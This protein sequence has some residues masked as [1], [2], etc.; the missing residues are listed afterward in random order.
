M[1]KGFSML[2]ISLYV[3]ILATSFQELSIAASTLE[4]RGMCSKS[5]EFDRASIVFSVEHLDKKPSIS[6][7]KTRSMY[8]KLLISFKALKLKHAKFKTLSFNVFEKKKWVQSSVGSGSGSRQV[9]LGHVAQMGLKVET[10]EFTRI[11]ELITSANKLGIKDIS[12]FSAFLSPKKRN[13]V[14]LKCLPIAVRNAKNKAQVLSESSGTKL[15]KVLKLI[16]S[17]RALERSPRPHQDAM[18][19]EAGMMSKAAAAPLAI[20]GGEALVQ[21]FVYMQYEV[22]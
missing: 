5:T 16:E 20:Q 8:N 22:K 12:Q 2:R 17:S 19:A 6:I 11:G 7:S 10:S 1:E 15:R 14:Y 13:E 18:Y 4:V 3:F 21:A 9:S